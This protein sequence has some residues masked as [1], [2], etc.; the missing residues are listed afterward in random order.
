MYMLWTKEYIDELADFIKSIHKDGNVL[1]VGAGD[2]MLSYW[3]RDRGIP[4]VATDDNTWK[5]T[6]RAPVRKLGVKK[7]IKEY[8]P[9]VVVCSWPTMDGK[10]DKEIFFAEP[11]KVILIGEGAGGCTGSGEVWNGLPRKLGYVEESSFAFDEFALCRTDHG[12]GNT[13]LPYLHIITYYYHKE[14]GL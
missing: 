1:E 10:L 14:K 5:I 8:N 2:G 6:A 13:H 3:L 11:P 12:F 4:V 9:E 7:A